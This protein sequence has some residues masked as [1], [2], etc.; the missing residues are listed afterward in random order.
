MTSQKLLP[1]SLI[2]MLMLIR[3]APV[4]SQTFTKLDSG[5]VDIFNGENFDGL[6][7]RMY[8]QDVTDV[9]DMVFQVDTENKIADKWQC[10]YRS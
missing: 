5:W 7:S 2:V 3:P 1:L 4:Y 8:Q 6:Y 10:L 9:P